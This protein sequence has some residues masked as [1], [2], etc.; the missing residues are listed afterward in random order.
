MFRATREGVDGSDDYEEKIQLPGPIVKQVEKL[1][2]VSHVV[3]N[4][5]S[6]RMLFIS[7]DKFGI[8]YRSSQVENKEIVSIIYK[9]NATHKQSSDHSVIR[10]YSPGCV[11]RNRMQQRDGGDRTRNF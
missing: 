5:H 6:L 1:F 7:F 9:Y 2:F 11:Y 3:V 4:F 8:A 10:N